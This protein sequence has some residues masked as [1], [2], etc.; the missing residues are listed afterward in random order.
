MGENK[1]KGT[2]ERENKV[3]RAR[4]Q[5]NEGEREREGENEREMCVSTPSSCSSESRLITGTLQHGDINTNT[6]RP[7][8]HTT[9]GGSED[10]GPYVVL[11]T[12]AQHTLWSNGQHF[13][14]VLP[15]L[16]WVT[17]RSQP[18]GP[19]YPALNTTSAAC[20]TGLIKD[21][22]QPSRNQ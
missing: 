15:G 19:S 6:Q 9:H 13:H 22:E 4:E 20:S 2:R 10:P 14:S 21:M 16:E 11:M 5:E 8:L 7:A 1:N 12:G 3:E 17:G 18:P